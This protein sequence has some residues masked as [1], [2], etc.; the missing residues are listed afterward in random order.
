MPTFRSVPAQEIVSVRISDTVFFNYGD[1]YRSKIRH[2]GNEKC[3]F[4]NREEFWN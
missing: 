3:D 1:F 4:E 2:V